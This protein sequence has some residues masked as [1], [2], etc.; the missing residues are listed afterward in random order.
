MDIGRLRDADRD[1]LDAMLQLEAGDLTF[2]SA[3]DT[4]KVAPLAQPD[5]VC[6]VCGLKH[7]QAGDGTVSS[8]DAVPGNATT[9]YRLEPGSYVD[10]AI[11]TIGDSDWFA[12]SLTA[13]QTY[14]FSVLPRTLTDNADLQDSVLTLRSDG[15]VQIASNDDAIGSFLGSEIVYTPT[16]SGTFYLD[17]TGYAA[18]TGGYLLSSSRPLADGVAGTASST[19]GLTLGAG[20]TMGTLDQTGDHDWYRVTL[21]AGQTYSFTTTATANASTDADTTLTVRTASGAFLAF[22]DDSS[23]TY[24]GLRFTAAESGTYFLDVGGWAESE[25]GAYQVQAAVA[26]PLRAFSNDEIADQLIAGYWG[27]ASYARHF[28]VTPGGSITYNIEA[29]TADGR[30]LATRALDLWSDVLGIAFNPVTAGGQIVFDDNA[31]GAFATSTRRGDNIVSS[32]IN[33]STSWL[34]SYGTTIDSY[35]FQTY[36][37]EIGHALGLGHAGNYNS[38]ADYTQDASY[39]NDAWATTIMSYFDQHENSFF[40]NQGFTRAEAITPMGAD[41][42]AIQTL[43]GVAATTRTGDTVYGVG[44]TSGRDVYGVG[45]N[46]TDADGRLLAFTI[47][48]HGGIDTLD[49]SSFSAA[50]RIDLNPE[51]FSNVGGSIGNMSIARGT[52]IENAVGGSGADFL[53]GNGF[54]NVLR[55]NGGDDR[56]EGG[57]G[58]DIAV[59]SGRMASTTIEHIGMGAY[60]VVGADGID[61]LDNIEYVR[62]DDMTARLHPHIGS[63]DATTF[64]AV[65]GY[66]RDFDG[67]RYGGYGGNGG[68]QWI[69]ATDGNGDRN[70][71]QLF[72]NA[73]IGRFATMGVRENHSIFSD[74]GLR[75]ETRLPDIH[76]DPLASSGPRHARGDFDSRTLFQNDLFAANINRVADSSNYLR[77]GLHEVDFAPSDGAAYLDAYMP[78]AGNMRDANYRSEAQVREF[79][80]GYGAGEETFVDWFANTAEPLDAKATAAA[81][82]T[83]DIATAP[84]PAD[85][86][87]IPLDT[88]GGLDGYVL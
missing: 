6:A 85:L 51:T 22:N 10:N 26:E 72:V 40:S 66:I 20:A 19:A 17:V 31:D 84:A 78:V 8:L 46:A 81:F 49:Y 33:V 15:G 75:G 77:N 32:Q 69:A 56:M 35:S 83:G 86:A 87:A 37:H 29:L 30:F 60:R 73:S 52:V 45:P 28:D 61:Y 44:N 65:V 5:H 11:D 42:V 23:G 25:S 18:S 14:I 7:A 70:S 53:F 88:I 82:Q 62:F 54:D 27:G 76:F 63:S 9:G 16:A 3:I 57:D 43:Y 80:T 4:A 64:R 71:D 47:V 79:L 36:L 2:D 39:L 50:Q 38:D 24:S 34:S 48:D 59:F 67:N 41:I 13:G 55:G 12:I 68:W 21:E 74:F 58:V 1:T